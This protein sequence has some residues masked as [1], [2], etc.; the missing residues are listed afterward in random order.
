MRIDVFSE[1]AGVLVSDRVAVE[2]KGSEW[3]INSLIRMA[4]L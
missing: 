4:A 1:G 2:S 3:N